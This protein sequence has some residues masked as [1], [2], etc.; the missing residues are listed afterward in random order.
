MYII[1]QNTIVYFL[2]SMYAYWTTQQ[3]TNKN[4]TN[5]QWSWKRQ[6][7]TRR[8]GRGA[9]CHLLVVTS[10]SEKPTNVDGGGGSDIVMLAINSFKLCVNVSV[11][12]TQH[13]HQHQHRDAWDA[14]HEDCWE[15][16]SENSNYYCSW[17]YIGTRTAT[18]WYTNTYSSTA[19]P[20]CSTVQLVYMYCKLL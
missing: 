2:I 15:C 8:A 17:I 14:F 6:L 3:I 20:V 18:D 4:K 11:S 12:N 9:V 1:D 19:V 13:Q 7:Q 5:I 16:E 10:A